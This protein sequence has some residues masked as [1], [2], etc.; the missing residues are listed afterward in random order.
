MS[1][2]RGDARENVG[3]PCLRIDAVHLGVYAERRTMPM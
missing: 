2:M 1:W 3:Q